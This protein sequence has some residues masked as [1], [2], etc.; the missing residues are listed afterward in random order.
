MLVPLTQSVYVA[1]ELADTE[2]VLL[3]IGTGYFM[4]VPRPCLSPLNGCDPS[5]GP[6][7]L[8]AKADARLSCSQASQW[9][10]TL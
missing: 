2:H 5:P 3:D 9:L 7:S 8:W 6:S 4:E 1:A 10:S